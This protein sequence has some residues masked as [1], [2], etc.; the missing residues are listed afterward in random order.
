MDMSP[1]ETVAVELAVPFHDVDSLRVVWH[2]HYLKYLEIARME[3]L[4][5]KRLDVEELERMRLKMMVIES[6][7]RHLAP[8]CYGDR[9]RVSARLT[10]VEV[11]VDV[12]FEVVN[13]ASG[14][15]AATGRQVLVLV[16]DEDE[17]GLCLRT[18]D[19][20]QERLRAPPG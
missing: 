8:L 5:R 14:R 9:F 19:E 7:L 20:V 3:L 1:S 17:G 6:H 11:R 18:P 2:G 15:R 13:L 12:A 16:R 10:E 4:R